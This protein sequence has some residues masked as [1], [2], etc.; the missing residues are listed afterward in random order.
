MHG[1]KRLVPAKARKTA[2]TK[3]Q[4]PLNLEEEEVLRRAQIYLLF[5][6][7]RPMLWTVAG[8][9][10]EKADDNSRRWIVAV[11]LRYPTGFEGYLGDLLVDGDRITEL[12][13]LKIM[14]ERAPNRGRSRRASTVG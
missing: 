1:R 3:R 13:D 5:E 12:T 9:R 6:E 2:P 10:E 8:I 7:K 4:P 11:N 14:Q